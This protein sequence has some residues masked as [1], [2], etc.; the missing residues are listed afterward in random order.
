MTTN[1]EAEAAS[2]EQNNAALIAALDETSLLEA[3]SAWELDI[4]NDAEHGRWIASLGPEATQNSRIG[5]SAA[6]SY[7]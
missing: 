4:V 3:E 1:I 2:R 5:S 6:A 7:C